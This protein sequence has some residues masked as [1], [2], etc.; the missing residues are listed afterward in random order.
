MPSVS[1]T[2]TFT[3]TSLNPTDWPSR[4][5]AAGTISVGNGQLKLT[6]P[7]GGNDG[8]FPEV[9]SRHMLDLTLPF[10]ITV[11]FQFASTCVCGTGIRFSATDSDTPKLWQDS[12]GMVLTLGTQ[13]QTYAA[14]TDAHTLVFSR[15]AFGN[16]SVKLDNHAALTSTQSNLGGNPIFRFG[17][18]CCPGSG[19][20]DLIITKVE[21]TGTLNAS[22]AGVRVRVE[23][24][25]EAEAKASLPV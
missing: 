23:A 13:T 20:S 19:W 2:D 25:A 5:A 1:F 15:D 21:A 3:E 4:N 11:N 17:N 22:V 10:T 18:D 9:R 16:Y 6:G 12:N 14:N 24:G 8:K 7:S